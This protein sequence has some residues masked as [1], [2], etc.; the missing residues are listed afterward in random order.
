MKRDRLKQI[1]LYDDL[2]CRA[3]EAIEAA[4]EKQYH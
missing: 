3:F 1:P 4:R 2:I